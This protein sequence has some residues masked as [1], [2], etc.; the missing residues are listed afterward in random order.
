M[1]IFAA[2]TVSCSQILLTLAQAQAMVLATPTVDA[3]RLNGAIPFFEAADDAPNGW[4]FTVNSAT[5]CKTSNP[6]STLI[7]HFAV[8][9]TGSVEDLDG[10]DGKLIETP[11]L[12]DMRRSFLPRTCRPV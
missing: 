5:P 6:C 7:G 1:P 11:L 4:S 8:S 9:R 2:M 12:H 3:A 10:D